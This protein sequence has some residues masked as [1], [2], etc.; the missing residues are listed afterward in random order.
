MGIQGVF[1]NQATFEEQNKFNELNLR[2]VIIP[3][4]FNDII[5]GVRQLCGKTYRENRLNIIQTR[6]IDTRST[7]L[8][9]GINQRLD[10]SDN[11]AYARI[12]IT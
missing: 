1:G 9:F 5:L 7:D 10:F 3:N 12:S 6:N 8:A 11:F 4:Q 2:G